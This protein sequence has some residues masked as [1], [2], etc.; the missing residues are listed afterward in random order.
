[1]NENTQIKKFFYVIL[2]LVV[3]LVAYVLIKKN[4]KSGEDSMYEI[5][6]ASVNKVDVVL[7]ETFPVE[8]DVKVQGDL[9]DG[10]TDIGDIKQNLV[11]N[12]FNINLETKKLKDTDVVCT[13]ALV[14]FV[15]NFPLENVTGI[16]AGEYKVNVNGVEKTFK[17][18]VDNYISNVDP[19]K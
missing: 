11:G 13:Q 4:K 14:P 10:C 12:T 18:D 17:M 1:M 6:Q 3:V 19:L 15:S 16:S 2:A 9:P 8:V 7:R 5:G